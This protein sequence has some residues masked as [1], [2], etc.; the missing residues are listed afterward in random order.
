MDTVLYRREVCDDGREAL[1]LAA[2]S[3]EDLAPHGARLQQ[4]G[5]VDEAHTVAEARRRA[6]GLHPA[7][8]YP[9]LTAAEMRIWTWY[10]PRA[11][12]RCGGVGHH[13]W[14]APRSTRY[15]F[16]SVPA[17]VLDELDFCESLAL[18]DDY[19]IRTPE[20]RLRD[21]DPILCGLAYPDPYRQG[22]ATPY[23]LARWGEA[24]EPWTSITARYHRRG[25]RGWLATMESLWR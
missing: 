14:L 22:E 13:V 16:A 19:V 18:F 12:R 24:L 20:R 3:L 23:L 1:A 17:P 8:W 15:H 7:C 11:Y 25:W 5:F 21:L 10:L 9:A 4:H 6:L 2:P